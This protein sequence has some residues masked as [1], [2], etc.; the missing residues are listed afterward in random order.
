MTHARPRVPQ[1]GDEAG[2]VEP[3]EPPH[4]PA[5]AGQPQTPRRRCGRALV[6]YAIAAATWILDQ[7]TK[8]LAVKQV[9]YGSSA[10]AVAG[11]VSITPVRN[12]NAAWNIPVPTVALILVSTAVAGALFIYGTRAAA[13]TP[14]LM[15]ALSL[16]LGGATG[17]LYDRLRWAAVVDFIDLHFWPTFNVADAAITVG[18]LL[19]VVCVILHKPRREPRTP[20]HA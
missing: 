2:E 1:A 6:F 7:S 8:W 13:G 20:A 9:G 17:N 15:V 19:I 12:V 16:L 14:A 4:P 10:T 11:I 3:H 18:T 5:N